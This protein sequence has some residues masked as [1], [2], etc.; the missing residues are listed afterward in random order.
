MRG[1]GIHSDVEIYATKQCN[2]DQYM[3]LKRRGGLETEP[4]AT[5]FC[6]V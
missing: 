4:S 2:E 1:T 6:E 5:S 3:E